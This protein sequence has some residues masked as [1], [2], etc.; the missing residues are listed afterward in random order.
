M[1]IINLL[2]TRNAHK[3]RYLSGHDVD[4]RT[5]HEATDRRH[6]DELDDPSNPEDTNTQSNEATDEGDS[7]SNNVWR[8]LP[9]MFVVNVLDYLRDSERHDS[10]GTDGD[11][12]GGSEELHRELSQRSSG[13]HGNSQTYT[14]DQDAHEGGV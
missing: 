3:T 10:D 14:I 8:P 6:R 12:L 5:G 2:K 9:G 7:S 13:A 1:F 4:S 11:I